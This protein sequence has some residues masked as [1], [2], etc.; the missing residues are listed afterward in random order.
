MAVRLHSL[1]TQARIGVEMTDK[2][3]RFVREEK[4]TERL[5]KFLAVR[6]PE[7]SR[8]RIQGLIREGFILVDNQ[9]PGKA[10]QQIETGQVIEVRIPPLQPSELMAEEIPLDIMFENEDVMVVNKPAGMVVHPA[11]GHAHGTLVNAAL[12]R[13]SGLQG[14]SGERRPGVVHRLDKETSGIIL[15][16]KNDRSHHWLQEQFRLR[17]VEKIYLALV[18]GAPPTPKGRIETP[19]GRDPNHRQR[20][21][22]VSQDK[23]RES[24]S[25]YFVQESFTNHTLLEIHP[26]TGRTH[27]IRVHMAFMGCPVVGDKL[28]GRRKSSINLDRHFL[29]AG[30]LKIFLPGEISSRMFSAPLPDELSKILDELRKQ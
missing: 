10:G 27:Q 21:A 17:R 14:I 4:G 23:G 22:V 18:D 24:V 28:Y 19:I 16:A 29:H 6:M 30:S 20:M 5:D 15:L 1:T 9:V 25:E 11:V 3:L 12:S 13:L 7:M 26:L 8:S 2:G